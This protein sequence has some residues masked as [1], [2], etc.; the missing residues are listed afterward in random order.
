MRNPTYWPDL[1][2]LLAIIRFFLKERSQEIIT[3]VSNKDNPSPL[4]NPYD[5]IMLTKVGETVDN[6]MDMPAIKHPMM[7]VE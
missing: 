1:E 5:I 4:I 7:H 3:L 2:M 6:E